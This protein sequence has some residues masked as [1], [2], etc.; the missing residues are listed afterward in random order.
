MP[1]KIHD[2]SLTATKR[3]VLVLSLFDLH[4]LV[5]VS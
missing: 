2:T 3:I 5:L 1:Y 4:F